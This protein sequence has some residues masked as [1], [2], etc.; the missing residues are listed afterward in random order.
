MHRGMP[1]TDDDRSPWLGAI[2]DWIDQTRR[3]GGHAV[4]ACSALKRS[5]RDILV[6]DRHEVRLVYLEGDETLIARRMATRH[7]HFMP[8]SLLRSQFETLEVPGPDENPITV[9]IVRTPHEIVARIL[10]SL[11]LSL[12]AR[13]LPHGLFR[14]A[15]KR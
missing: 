8:P 9:S 5:Y 6:G 15:V 2:A 1:L 7:G 4:L 14:P 13:P 10:A 3:A 12:G 11:D